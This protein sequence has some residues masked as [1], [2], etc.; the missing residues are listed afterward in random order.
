MGI[1][2]RIGDDILVSM[3]KSY[4]DMHRMSHYPSHSDRELGHGGTAGTLQY[5]E[6]AISDF[7]NDLQNPH[8]TLV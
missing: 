7:F 2:R 4:L 5:L 6:T 1:S 3:I 8:V